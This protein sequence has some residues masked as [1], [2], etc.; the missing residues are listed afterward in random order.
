[1]LSCLAHFPAR[2]TWDTC[3]LFFNVLITDVLVLFPGK[4]GKT[5]SLSTSFFFSFLWIMMGNITLG[6]NGP[7]WISNAVAGQ[8]RATPECSS[9]YSFLD[10]HAYL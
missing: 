3:L 2:A 7:S 4:L 1:M 5:F 6:T 9:S 8:P 10:E